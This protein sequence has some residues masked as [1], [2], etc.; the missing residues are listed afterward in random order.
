M[1]KYTAHYYNKA[2]NFVVREKG[3]PFPIMYG[4][5][6]TEA[7]HIAGKLNSNKYYMPWWAGSPMS[8][9]FKLCRWM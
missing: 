6:H 5:K 7:Q 8:K 3:T 4:L 9:K 1:K 2:E